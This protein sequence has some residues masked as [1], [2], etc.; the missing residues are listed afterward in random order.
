TARTRR[1]GRLRMFAVFLL[2][3]LIGV[4]VGT[5]LM[6]TLRTLQLGG[7]A[8]GFDP[9]VAVNF[10]I[11]GPVRDVENNTLHI[12]DL[13]VAIDDAALLDQITA[14][15]TVRIE[16]RFETDQSGLR[17][18]AYRSAKINGDV[19]PEPTATPTASR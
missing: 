15:D 16:G 6:P 11:E 17:L 5:A 9:S 2:L 19:Y 8:T 13:A 1:R 18:V 7:S 12:Y 4:G 14:G 3:V 10:T